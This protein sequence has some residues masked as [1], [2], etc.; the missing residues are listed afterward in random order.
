M[1]ID[2]FR[3]GLLVSS[4]ASVSIYILSD[5]AVTDIR[6]DGVGGDKDPELGKCIEGRDVGLAFKCELKLSALP[7]TLRLDSE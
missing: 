5:M 1:K 7:V 4:C 6:P 2:C 3:L